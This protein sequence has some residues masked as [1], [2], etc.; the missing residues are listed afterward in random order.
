VIEAAR[1]PRVTL[2]TNF[3]AKIAAGARRAATVAECNGRDWRTRSTERRELPSIDVESGA[4]PL[5]GDSSIIGK[6]LVL[7]AD[8]RGKLGKA[9]ACGLIVATG[10]GEGAAIE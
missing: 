9:V 2:S 3:R 6:A 7:H 10:D 1:R 8:R 5:D 4:L